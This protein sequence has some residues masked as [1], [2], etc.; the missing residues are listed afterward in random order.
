MI[1]FDFRG[2]WLQCVQR[3]DDTRNRDDADRVSNSVYIGRWREERV[4]KYPNV[5]PARGQGI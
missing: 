4:W 3:A 1:S 2:Q 5:R